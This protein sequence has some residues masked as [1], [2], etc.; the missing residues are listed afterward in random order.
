[1]SRQGTSMPRLDCAH[2]NLIKVC[3]WFSI[4]Y[5]KVVIYRG[6][7]GDRPNLA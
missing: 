7:E 2:G 1:M 6:S 5:I 3:V 4:K